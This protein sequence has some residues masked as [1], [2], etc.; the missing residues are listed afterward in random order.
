MILG[1]FLVLLIAAV[2][3]AIGA[4][5]RVVLGLLFPAPAPGPDDDPRWV[6]PGEG[7][8]IGRARTP[9][10]AFERGS[11]SIARTLRPDATVP[12]ARL[13][14]SPESR[15]VEG[16]EGPD[17]PATTGPVGTAVDRIA[18]RF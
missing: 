16:A 12:V 13:A 15:R 5:G 18:V 17:R 8:R 10:E 14:Q 11:T 7:A 1:L 6:R 4:L 3:V 2:S 9:G